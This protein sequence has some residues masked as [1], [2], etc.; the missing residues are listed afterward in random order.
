MDGRDGMTSFYLNRGGVSGSGFKTQPNPNMSHG[1]TNMRMPSSMSSPF[2]MEPNSS[3]NLHHDINMGGRGGVV[4][5][6][7]PGSGNASIVKKK[8]GRPRKYA[9]DESDME[10][11]LTPAKSMP[12]SLGGS[13]S[14][15][16]RKNRGRPPGSGWKQRLANVGMFCFVINSSWFIWTMWKNL[17]ILMIARNF[18]AF[19]N[20][21]YL[22]IVC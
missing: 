18:M 20:V 12:A 11:G 14:P 8:R 7:L 16:M 17:C 3:P 22:G 21:V 13:I 19:G 6:T 10:L 1:H 15:M 2:K 9:R 5:V 4:P